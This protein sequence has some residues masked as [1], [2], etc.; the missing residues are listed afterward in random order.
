M[1]RGDKDIKAQAESLEA[2]IRKK[3]TEKFIE[4]ANKMV[5]DRSKLLESREEV[6]EEEKSSFDKGTW[7]QQ[8]EK[9]RLRTLAAQ[10]PIW[11]KGTQ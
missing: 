6:S 4:D 3:E 8:R 1:R 2:E 7:E 9:G 10:L 5:R 11:I